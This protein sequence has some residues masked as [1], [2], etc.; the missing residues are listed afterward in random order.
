MTGL[1]VSICWLSWRCATRPSAWQKSAGLL[2]KDR[3]PSDGPAPPSDFSRKRTFIATPYGFGSNF[4]VAAGRRLANVRGTAH[5]N[6]LFYILNE[7]VLIQYLIVNNGA[8]VTLRFQGDWLKIE[9]TAHQ[10]KRFCIVN[11]NIFVNNGAIVTFF[12][13]RLIEDW[14]NSLNELTAALAYNTRN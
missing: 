14:I 1:V 6:K 9:Q 2:S 4:L 3:R 12:S 7:N 13:G 5:Q 8:I 10:N 11:E